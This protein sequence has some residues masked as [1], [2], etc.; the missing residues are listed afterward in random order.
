MLFGIDAHGNLDEINQIPHRNNYEAW[1]R[2]LSETNF[3]E[4]YDELSSRI[5]L[6]PKDNEA[7]TS[8]WIPG[9]DWTGTVFQPIYDACNRDYENAAK[10]FG[11][12]LWQVV[13]EDPNDWSFGKYQDRYGNDIAG[14]TYF[15]IYPRR[16]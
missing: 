2:N 11:L 3:N 5:N 15:R 7:V 13:M 6:I 10:F 4:I 12:I 9:N 8:S 1:M 16:N 14:T